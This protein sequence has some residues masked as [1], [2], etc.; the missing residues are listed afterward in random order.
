MVRPIFAQM[1]NSPAFDISDI[2]V[3]SEVGEGGFR[4]IYYE[5]SSGKHFITKSN[6]T[7]A[8]PIFSGE[9]IVWMGQVAG[10]SWQIFR[11]HI[12]TGIIIQLRG[13]INNAN[14]K[15]S[16]EGK[17]VWEGWAEKSGNWQIFFF[18]GTKIIQLTSGDM[19]INPDI[20]GDYISYARRD[21]SG[22]WRSVIYSISKD[23]AF[24]I[25]TG[26]SSKKPKIRQG[27][28]ILSGKGYDEEF[29]LTIEDFFLLNL[30]PLS[31]TESSQMAP[32]PLPTSKADTNSEP[33]TTTFEE[34][35]QELETAGLGVVEEER[36]EEGE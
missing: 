4:Q 22:T 11:Y 31:A 1:A 26:I 34:V 5:D 12:P 24:E 35:S 32:T 36:F 20:E 6:Y 18:D 21:V 15:V 19:S 25:T 28:I 17:V 30:V 2:Q 16:L 29:P 27:K 23:K 14:P 7:N 13:G 9:Y 10:G 3:G 8:E 33:D